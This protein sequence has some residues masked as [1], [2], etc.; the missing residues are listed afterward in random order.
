MRPCGAY[1]RLICKFVEDF[2]FFEVVIDS[3][4][5]V[6]IPGVAVCYAWIT[7]RLGG[8]IMSVDSVIC[9]FHNAFLATLIRNFYQVRAVSSDSNI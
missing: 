9:Y 3:V 1:G 6:L 4:G 2:F 7:V 5:V 8:Y